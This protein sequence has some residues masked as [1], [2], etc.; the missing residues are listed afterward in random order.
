MAPRL[1]RYAA[2]AG[3]IG[4]FAVIALMGAGSAL[5]YG[6]A[7]QPIAQV[8]ISANC[9]NLSF[10]NGLGIPLGGVWAW[11]ELDTAGGSESGGTMDYT[12]AFCGHT[13][14]GGGP[15][16]A[17]AFGHPGVGAWTLFPNPGEA[18]TSAPG[19]SPFFDSSTY[20]GAVYVLDFKTGQGEDD[21]MAAVPASYGH[22]SSPGYWPAG[23]QFQTQVAP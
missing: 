20:D 13:G 8:E 6:S 4:A 5:A 1:V 2:L 3:A 11:A 23:A 22:Y 19:A 17:G 21:F 9:N 15:H 18:L 7:D 12:L 10:C 14:P 16:S